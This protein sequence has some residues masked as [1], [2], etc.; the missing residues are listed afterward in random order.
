MTK[1]RPEVALLRLFRAVERKDC[2]A[3]EAFE[4]FVLTY[5]G[6]KN[7]YIRKP[8]GLEAEMKRISGLKHE[9]RGRFMLVTDDE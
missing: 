3:D 7:L 8:C 1:P 2:T 6:D 5:G 9:I 4:C